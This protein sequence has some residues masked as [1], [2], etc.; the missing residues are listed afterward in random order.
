LILLT[1]GASSQLLFFK[2]A[3][4][5]FAPCFIDVSFSVIV[6]KFATK[7]FTSCKFLASPTICTTA[8]DLLNSH[9]IFFL[10]WHI[11]A[12][13]TGAAIHGGEA[14]VN[15]SLTRGGFL[16]SPLKLWLAI[17]LLFT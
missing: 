15:G 4:F 3:N 14:D 2:A 11:I 9:F 1:V 16:P 6:S 12:V 5:H 7:A 13:L 10:F 17:Q 8:S